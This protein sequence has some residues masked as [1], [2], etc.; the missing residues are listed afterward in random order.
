MR[1]AKTLF[2]CAGVW[3]VL[4]LTPMFFLYERLGTSPP[5]PPTHPEF[6]FG[7]LSV[8]LAWQF[9]F[10]IIASDP[11]RFRLLMLPAVLEKLG[12]VLVLCTLYE[13]G[14]I[15]TSQFAP[16][17][18]DGLLCLLFVIAFSKT[19]PRVAPKINLTRN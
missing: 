13:Q 19:R 17:A 16:A 2:W 14:R 15:T 4:I 12:Y 7:F 18:P 11:E 8:T 6:Y 9:A 3:G 10:F 1:F 5:L